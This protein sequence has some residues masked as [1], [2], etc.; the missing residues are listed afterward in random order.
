M[1]FDI[2][3]G[4]VSFSLRVFQAPSSGPKPAL[5]AARGH[6]REPGAVALQQPAL[7]REAGRGLGGRL[8]QLPGGAPGQPRRAHVPERKKLRKST[9]VSEPKS[10]RWQGYPQEA[11]ECARQAFSIVL[12]V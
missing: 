3:F 9:D 8:P 6:H 2:H 7:R 11:C 10:M 4:A 1:V 12:Q 5:R